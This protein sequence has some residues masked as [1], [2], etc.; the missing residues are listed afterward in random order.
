[1]AKTQLTGTG[2]PGRRYG[3]FGGRGPGPHL[4]GRVTALTGT[5]LP[6]RRYG[7]F[8]RASVIDVTGDSVNVT[9]L[10]PTLGTYGA[11]TSF[12]GLIGFPGALG[13][14]IGVQTGFTGLIGVGG[15]AAVSVAW[16]TSFAGLIGV[17]GDST[18]AAGRQTTFSGLFGPRGA[19]DFALGVQTGFTG[20]LGI[21]AALAAALG[22]DTAFVGSV[23][24]LGLLRA[25]DPTS[26]VPWWKQDDEVALFFDE[27]TVP[28]LFRA[29]TVRGIFNNATQLALAGE[30]DASA[31]V[32]SLAVRTADVAGV[33][34]GET[35]VVNGVTYVVQD[36][37]NDA[38]GV[39][40][41]QLERA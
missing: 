3:S 14:G 21:Q 9:D 27:W 31:A 35:V 36:V 5:G 32:P 30:P 25:A 29:T 33:R 12:S 24:L 28:V 22:R 1:M 38:T 17:L 2:L 40:R 37:N 11:V 34:R 39:T 23:G 18:T 7:S 20:L 26:E 10:Q 15:G 4:V 13:Y 16:Q 6:G 19:L 41:L 8:T